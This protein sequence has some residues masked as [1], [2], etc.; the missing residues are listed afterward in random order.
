[1]AKKSLPVEKLKTSKAKPVPVK[2]VSD[3]V[4][5]STNKIDKD[6]E[7]KWQAEDDLRTMQRAK[8]IEADKSRVAAMKSL[9]QS[10]IADL[11]KI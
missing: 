2:I 8:E 3:T 7:R 11:K 5:C 1:M 10:Q 9:A 6:R 4:S